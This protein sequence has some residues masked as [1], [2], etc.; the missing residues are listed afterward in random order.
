MWPSVRAEAG[1]TGA[2]KS[3]KNSEKGIGS[4]GKG[5]GSSL[6]RRQSAR[7]TVLGSFIL[8]ATGIIP[9]TTRVICWC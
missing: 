2:N 3:V 7:T 1:F 5:A 4:D 6:R 8:R 9:T